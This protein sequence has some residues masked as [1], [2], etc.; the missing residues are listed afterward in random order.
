MSTDLI[1]I[2]PGMVFDVVTT[3]VLKAGIAAILGRCVCKVKFT[4]A[5]GTERIM[6]CTLKPNILPEPIAVD[7]SKVKKAVSTDIL[8]VYDLEALAKDPEHSEK[9][10]RSFRIDSVK[11][12]EIL[13]DAR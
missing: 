3:E 4:K 5:D 9:A 10:W 13:H 6:R 8:A 12:I 2:D 11:E 1:K 7:S